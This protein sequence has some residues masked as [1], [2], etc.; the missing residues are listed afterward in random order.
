MVLN[1][2]GVKSIECE[3]RKKKAMGRRNISKEIIHEGLYLKAGNEKLFC[4]DYT[5][6]GVSR[7]SRTLFVLNSCCW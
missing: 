7:P 3:C 4:I 6:F 2:V 5:H 1:F